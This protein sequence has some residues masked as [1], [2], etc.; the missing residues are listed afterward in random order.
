VLLVLALLGCVPD[1]KTPA[2]GDE[3]TPTGTTDT[4]TS[5]DPAA[6]CAD[7][8]FGPYVAWNA[9]GPYGTDRRDLAEDFTM[10]MADGTTWSLA[11]RWTGC[12]QYVFIPDTIYRKADNE[13]SVWTKGLDELVA[14]SPR[15]T[16][17]FFV[18]GLSG[19]EADTSIADMESEVA[20]V[21]AD[22]SA[23]D[24]AWWAERLHVAEVP[25]EDLEGWPKRVLRSGIGVLGFGI[26]RYQA[27]RGVGSWA[28]DT[29]S[30]STNADWP[31]Q[32]NLAF[33][34]HEARLFQMEAERQA[35]LDA[36]DATVV[37]LWDGEVIEEYEDIEVEL[38]SADEMATFDTF[39]IDIDMR[40]PDHGEIEAGNCGAWDYIANLYV[41][42]D[43]GSWIE[44]SRF[45]TSYHRETRWVADA[46]PMLPH[47][48]A[49]GTR[50]FRWSW[51]PSWNTQPTETRLSLRFSDQGK[52]MKPRAATLVATGGSFGSTYNDGRE[53][54]DVPVSGDAKKVELWA[55]TTGH[56]MATNNCAEF[57]GTQHEFTVD[58]TAHL[59]DLV[60]SNPES[61]CVDEIENQM[62]PNQWGTWWYGRDGW[63]PGEVV[64]P[65]EADVTGDVG[66]DG[67]AT[68]SYRGL[69]EGQTPP[70]GAGEIVLNAWLVVYE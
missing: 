52:G 10:P 8:G 68:V 67:T 60:I 26:D 58:G 19:D 47:L 11:E 38:P 45:I 20:D 40:C 4:G 27:L 7:N 30:D 49:G 66:D 18:S 61:G 44:L 16:H 65:Y 32:N 1:D 64:H 48:L 69:F 2:G 29:L 14:G 22:L 9:E 28:D 21:L 24:A 6:W 34:A 37:T 62:T 59:Q 36:F 51:A 50:T 41:A 42:D 53:P 63:C 57:C 31:F 46:T 33:A 39:E 12:E 54:V 3:T 55:I 5:P 25:A 23:E 35:R 13:K 15:N 17:Y 70:D 43:D 56:G